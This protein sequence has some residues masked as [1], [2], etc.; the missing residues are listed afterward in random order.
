MKD[1]DNKKSTLLIKQNLCC[2]VC[3]KKFTESDKIELAHNLINSKANIELFGEE[4]INHVLNLDATHSQCNSKV[5]INRA[6]R[7]VKAQEKIIEII[8]NI[9]RSDPSIFVYKSL[10][11]AFKNIGSLLTEDEISI[12]KYKEIQTFMMLYEEL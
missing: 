10:Q 2:S 6:T 7:P 9:L 8:D 4:I 12:Q 11:K 1:Y 5:I 3:N